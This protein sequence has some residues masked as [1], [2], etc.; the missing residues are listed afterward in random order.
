MFCACV[1]LQL[2]Q[3]ELNAV[4]A[5]LSDREAQISRLRVE[6]EQITVKIRNESSGNAEVIRKLNEQVPP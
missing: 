6:N 3:D 1:Q 4:R 2:S 5:S